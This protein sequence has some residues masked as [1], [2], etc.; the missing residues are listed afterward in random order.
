MTFELNLTGGLFVLAIIGTIFWVTR[1]KKTNS[2]TDQFQRYKQADV[3]LSPA[4]HGIKPSSNVKS[5][6]NGSHRVTRRVPR[7]RTNDNSYTSE[8][9]SSVH[10]PSGDYGSGSDGGSCGGE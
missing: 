5:A 6:R 3:T 7:K 2:S 8:L 4:Y 9:M 1:E 10:T